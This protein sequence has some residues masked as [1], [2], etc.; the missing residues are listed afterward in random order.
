MK[1]IKTKIT[2]YE[3]YVVGIVVLNI[4]FIS[5]ITIK[6]AIVVVMVEKIIVIKQTLKRYVE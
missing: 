5:F 2:K 1:I 6:F 3:M 4:F